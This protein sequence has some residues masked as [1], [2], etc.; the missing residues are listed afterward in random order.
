MTIAIFRTRMKP[1][2][3]MEEFI[4]LHHRIHRRNLF[5]S[6]SPGGILQGSRLPVRLSRFR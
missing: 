6:S 3:N 5:V 4:A 1:H 2:V